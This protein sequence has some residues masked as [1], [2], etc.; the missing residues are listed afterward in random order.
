MI[1]IYRHLIELRFENEM[2]YA[3][4]VRNYGD[5]FT[6]VSDIDNAFIVRGGE[7]LKFDIR[8]SLY[9]S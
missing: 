4:L 7:I 5:Y 8:R 1:L 9:D 6:A 3:Q 2:N